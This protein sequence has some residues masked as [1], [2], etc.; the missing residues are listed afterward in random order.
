MNN[1]FLPSNSFEIANSKGFLK[2]LSDEYGDFDKAHLN[3]RFAINC[4]ITSWHLTDW[5]YEEFY[6]KDE[7]FQDSKEGKKT[8]SGISKYQEFLKESCPELEYMRMITNGSKHC[9]VN[10]KHR[11]IVS[12]GDFSSGDFSRHDFAVPRFVITNE[13]SEEIDFEKLLLV[14]IDFWKKFLNRLS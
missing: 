8:V 2:K 6:K 10:Q 11:T 3:P 14:T 7:R 5:T 1:N 4:A 12:T 9:K 13:N